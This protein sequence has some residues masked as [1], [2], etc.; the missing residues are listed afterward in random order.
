MSKKQKYASVPITLEKWEAETLRRASARRASVTLA[1]RALT[2]SLD[3][4]VL[5]SWDFWKDIM[6]KYNL[7]PEKE[8][9]ERAGQIYE[10]W[11]PWSRP[12]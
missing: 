10:I 11:R 2:E 5:S 4:A 7:D 1:L 8:Y 3:D 12:K 6:T 9:Y